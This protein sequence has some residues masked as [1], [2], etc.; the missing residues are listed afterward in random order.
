[1]KHQKEDSRDRGTSGFLGWNG[2]RWNIFDRL[3][4]KLVT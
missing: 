1:V 2:L 4:Y 3:R